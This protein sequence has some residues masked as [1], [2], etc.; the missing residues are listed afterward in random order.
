METPQQ[1]YVVERKHQHLLN[2]ARAIYFQS[3]IPIS[4]WS[5]C[6]LTA[7]FLINRTPSLFLG[8]KTPFDLLYHHAA[9]YSFLRIFSCLAFASTLT[10]HRTKFDLRARICVFLGYPVGVKGYKLLDLHTKQ[11]F[12]S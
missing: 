3:R 4:F 6:I 11:I 12:I 10:T 9:D 2:V 5:E 1:N 7:A 8:N